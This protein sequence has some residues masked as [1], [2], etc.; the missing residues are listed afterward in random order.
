MITSAEFFRKNCTR[1]SV[2]E[3]HRLG[4]EDIFLSPSAVYFVHATFR[5][6][7]H[8]R[9]YERRKGTTRLRLVLPQHRIIL[10]YPAGEVLHIGLED[11]WLLNDP[12]QCKS[13]AVSTR[14]SFEGEKMK[15]GARVSFLRSRELKLSFCHCLEYSAACSIPRSTIY[16]KQTINSYETV[17]LL[18]LS[19]KARQSIHLKTEFPVSCV[20]ASR[21][22]TSRFHSLFALVPFGPMYDDEGAEP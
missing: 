12:Y 3:C 20:A 6:F 11:F 15:V 17:E 2:G 9:R 13:P 21:S 14:L 8:K 10:E 7:V 22:E 1:P 19:A 18:L 4:K 16:S 5:A